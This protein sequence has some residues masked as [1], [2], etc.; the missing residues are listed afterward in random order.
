MKKI[1]DMMHYTLES[2]HIRR[3]E[4]RE[5]DEQTID[6]LDPFIPRSPGLKGM[7]IKH[8]GWSVDLLQS[9]A[10][11][12]KFRLL[13]KS[14]PVATAWLCEERSAWPD[15]WSDAGVSAPHC[16]NGLW[17][18]WLVVS[19]VSMLSWIQSSSMFE[20]AS[21]SG[22]AGD[23]ERCVAWTLLRRGELA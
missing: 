14:R 23:F 4:R 1:L 18:P 6:S 5:V 15:I 21:V 12:K 9:T 2:G 8:T 11:L 19:M 13:H 3:S 20:M 7:T 17:R 16:P 22:E 10:A